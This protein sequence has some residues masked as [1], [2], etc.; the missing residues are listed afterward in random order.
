[1]I[2]FHGEVN[3]LVQQDGSDVQ[4]K[5]VGRDYDGR[6]MWQVSDTYHPQY[7]QIIY[8]RSTQ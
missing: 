5:Y 3:Y 7:G 1:M 2:R 8:L 4:V 6:E